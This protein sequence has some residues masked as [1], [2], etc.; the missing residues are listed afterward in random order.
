[1][2]D[3]DGAT[4]LGTT[5]PTMSVI[6]DRGGDPIVLKFTVLPTAGTLELCPMKEDVSW[7]L[8]ALLSSDVTVWSSVV[9]VF[10]SLQCLKEEDHLAADHTEVVTLAEVLL[11]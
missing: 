11:V 3:I 9:E 6:S 1:M 7:N 8:C 4:Q 10:A 2:G 5:S